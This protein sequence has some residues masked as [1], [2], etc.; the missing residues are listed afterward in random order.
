MNQLDVYYRALL[1]L[2]QQTVADNSCTAQ[3]SAFASADTEQD[4]IV[5]TRSLCKIDE[6]WVDA[7]E[8]GLI[9]IEKAIKEERQF[10][11]E[12]LDVIHLEMQ[13]H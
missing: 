2:R 5:T 11:V 13:S 6:D 10:I 12:I 9:H 8:A 4:K 7:I 1:D 3:R